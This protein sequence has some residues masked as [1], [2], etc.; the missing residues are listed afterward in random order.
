MAAHREY[1]IDGPDLPVLD[2]VELPK[3]HSIKGL[4]S[5]MRERPAPC[6]SLLG[7]SM[8]APPGVN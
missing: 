2:A 7:P 8:G 1:M 4:A 6:A 5:A 3:R